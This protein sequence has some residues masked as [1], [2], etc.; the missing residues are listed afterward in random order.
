MR[1]GRHRLTAPDANQF[2]FFDIV[3]S[4]VDASG[5]V[6]TGP[7]KT[8]SQ[9]GDA[10]NPAISIIVPV[11]NNEDRIESCLTSITTQSFSDIEIVV[12]DD[13]ST[14]GSLVLIEKRAAVDDRIK[15]LSYSENKSASQARK[16]GVAAA[17]G[18]YIMFADGGDELEPEICEQLVAEMKNAPADILHFNTTINNI[19]GLPPAQI[20]RLQALLF[21]YEGILED[22]EVLSKYFAEP[23]RSANLCNK[24]FRADVCK[25][26]FSRVA[27]GRFHQAEDAYAFFVIAYYARS[28][29]GLPHLYGHR[30]NLGADGSDLKKFTRSAF[31]NLCATG[32]VADNLKT[33]LEKEGVFELQENAYRNV[34]RS[35]LYDCFSK[36][37]DNLD[38]GDFA[39]GYDTLLKYWEAPE[40]LSLMIETYQGQERDIALRLADASAASPKITSVKTIGA[41]YHRICGGGAQRV[42][43]DLINIWKRMGY[44]VVLFTDLEPD[45]SDYLLPDDTP[46]VVLPSFFTTTKETYRTR[47]E[48]FSDACEHYGVDCLVYHAWES[49]LLLWDMLLAKAAGIPTIVHCHNAFSSVV[50]GLHRH[51]ATQPYVFRLA[52]ALVV[53]SESDRLYW[54][55]FATPVV[56]TINPISDDLK[57][58]AS[59]PTPTPT[60]LW[61]GRLADEKRPLDAVRILEKVL[62]TVPEAKLVLVGGEVP[63]SAFNERIADYVHD[64]GLSE[65]VSAV[66]HQD[67]VRPFYRTATIQL[68]TSEYEGYPLVIAEGKRFG[69]PC[70]MY[71]LPYLAF[72]ENPQGIVS[73]PQGSIEGAADAVC[74]LLENTE[75][76][77]ALSKEAR[78]SGRMLT[79]FDQ[80][81]LWGDLFDSLATPRNRKEIRDDELI[82]WSSLFKAYEQGN[83]R[84]RHAFDEAH[85]QAVVVREEYEQSR[86]YRIGRAIT[87]F[88]RAIKR[89][90]GKA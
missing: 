80:E 14:D 86:S 33:F 67:D 31:E 7:D 84:M 54:S 72:L 15:I 61:V 26:A 69:L 74:H 27:D 71:G 56:K 21:P 70:V 4:S 1:A 59:T 3:Y 34:R 12:I 9:K 63:G 19:A 17:H 46:R 76:Y 13:G 41:Y 28:Y 64:H 65:H 35:F 36:F 55:M 47:A 79:E 16:D 24:M 68:M 81:K 48:A 32:L 43:C 62:D 20:E 60:L 83:D 87:A 37:R 30:Y 40:I 53:L 5:N 25:K 75:H 66:G 77:Q 44:N 10:M 11:H 88:P 82:M 8:N 51:F 42:T 6:H 78:E 38:A 22:D 39:F 49:H 58:E 45:E 85:H 90:L 73:V 89:A 29:R 2:S 52:D 57:H 23:L 18:S 50:R